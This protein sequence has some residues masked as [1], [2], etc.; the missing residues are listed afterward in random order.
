MHEV[1]GLNEDIV[2]ILTLNYEDLLER[3]VQKIKNRIDYSIRMI[4][5]HSFLKIK[6]DFGFPILKL[7]GSFNWKNESPIRLTDDDRL[8]AEDVLWIPPGVEKRRENYPFSILWGRAREIL[9]CDIL[10]VIG[11][12]L[13]RNDWQLVSLLHTTQKLN[14]DGKGHS[15]ELINNHAACEKIQQ[16][17]SYLRF[18]P[19][20]DI[21]EVGES[22][23]RSLGVTLDD[24]SKAIKGFL[25]DEKLN[26]FDVWLRSKGESLQRNGISIATA[27][28]T[29]ENYMKE[30]I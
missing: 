4:S 28:G 12:S 5:D 17:Y 25:S 30:R 18:R 10:R 11:C 2:G 3:G 13:N 8:K 7:H 24:K 22:I 19:M 16:D 14:A 27:T 26:S 6:N 20:S 1:A 9:H 23:I 29:F 21:L 15:I